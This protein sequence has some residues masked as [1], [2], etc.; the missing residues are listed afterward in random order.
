MKISGRHV[1]ALPLT[2][3]AALALVAGCGQ[4][5]DEG[6]TTTNPGSGGDVTTTPSGSAPATDL[7][8]VL[9]DGAGTKTT[10]TLTCDPPG[11]D[12]PDPAAA[13][14]VLEAQGA[15]ALP[16]VPQDRMCT[17]NFGGPE[18]AT[19]TG[20]WKGAPVKSALSKGNGCEIARWKSLSGLLP[21]SGAT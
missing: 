14:A 7:T 20:T 17:M 13:C 12:H 2:A 21:G 3:M 10:W 19:I 8:I 9:D 16:P 11:G 15:A 5:A 4:A 18:T 1:L 6:T